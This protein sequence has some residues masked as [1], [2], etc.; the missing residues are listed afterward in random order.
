M[1]CCAVVLGCFAGL[2]FVSFCFVC[3]HRPNASM[4]KQ[5]K[6]VAL[7]YTST[8]SEVCKAR[9]RPCSCLWLRINIHTDLAAKIITR[10][11]T[12][13]RSRTPE[14]LTTSNFHPSSYHGT[15]QDT[16]HSLVYHSSNQDLTTHTP[17]PSFPS[18]PHQPNTK[19][20]IPV[21]LVKTDHETNERR[22][23][24][25]LTA[26]VKQTNLTEIYARRLASPQGYCASPV[27]LICA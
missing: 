6:G 14:L 12:S 5:K 15:T 11:S 16:P 19:T 4:I 13:D 23:A 9:Q 17:L 2:C 20:H 8:N 7:R 24:V 25:S 10:R 22:I 3:R 27:S 1:S 26:P 18:N 21:G